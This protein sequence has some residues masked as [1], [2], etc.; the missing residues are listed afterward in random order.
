MEFL[1]Y[2]SNINKKFI[3]HTTYYFDIPDEK[4]SKFNLYKI[5]LREVYYIYT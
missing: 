4:C 5:I 2:Y 3:K 1:F